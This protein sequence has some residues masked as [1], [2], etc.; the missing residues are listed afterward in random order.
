MSID[1]TPLIQAQRLLIEADLRPLQGSRFQPTG[2]PNLGH[3]VY[4]APDGS[5]Q[6]ILVES[7][8]S[9]ANRL[10]EVCWDEN[11][12]DWVAPLKGV[13]VIKVVDENGQPLTNSLLEP[14]RINSPY[15]LES[16]DTTV[17]D[18]LKDQVSIMEEGRVDIRQFARFLLRYDTNSLLH[19]AFVAKKLGGGRLRIARSL[20]SFI[21]A[22]GVNIAPSGGVKNDIVN[23]KAKDN[24]KG[25]GNVPF[26]RDEWTAKNIT[27]YF[28]LDIR[29]IRSFNLGDDVV[30]FL[31]GFALF[32]IAS[33]LNEGLRLRTA[34]DLELVNLDIKHPESF[35]M[36]TMDEISG[37][38]PN[39]ISKVADQDNFNDPSTTTVKYKK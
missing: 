23:P 3:A 6:F 8:Q 17:L 38:M 37:E 39:L 36:P 15:I 14:H 26:P 35:K 12:D 16:K 11:S 32:K 22:S 25:F 4:Q 5:E 27:A 29:Q 28:N 33:F 7:S 2:F 20:S 13:P 31:I 34:C 18:L 1:I 9:M 19:G 24:K 30:N 21:E 10:E